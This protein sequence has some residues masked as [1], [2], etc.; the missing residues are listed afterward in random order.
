MPNIDKII[1]IELDH[2]SNPLDVLNGIDS[3]VSLIPSFQD[4]GVMKS[5]KSIKKKLTLVKSETSTKLLM[6]HKRKRDEVDTIRDHKRIKKV[7]SL[8]FPFFFRI[9]KSFSFLFFSIG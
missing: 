1:E 3:L 4:E 6:S 7:Q 8:F 2:L 5:L 9:Q